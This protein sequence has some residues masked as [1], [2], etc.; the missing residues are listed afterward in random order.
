MAYIRKR[1][2]RGGKPAYCVYVRLR[3]YPPQIATFV[4]K[5]DARRWAQQTEA[6]IREGR[7]FKS[8]EAK[9]HLLAELLLAILFMRCDHLNAHCG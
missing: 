5:T 1:A 2:A 9:R 3:G 4:R 8:I 7:H 6:A